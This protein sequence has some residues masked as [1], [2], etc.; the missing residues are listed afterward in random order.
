MSMTQLNKQQVIAINHFG[1]PLMI[2]AGAGSGKTTV[3]TQKMLHLIEKLGFPGDQILAI[4]FTNKASREMS[5]RIK[6]L[7][8][9]AEKIPYI[10]TFHA[11]CGDVLRRNFNKIGGSNNFVIFDSSD[12][13]RLVKQILKEKKID[14]KQVRPESILSRIE[15]L[16]THLIGYRA[17]KNNPQKHQFDP[18]LAAIYEAY[19]LTLWHSKAVDFGD[20][21]FWVNV[22]FKQCPEVLDRYQ[23]QYKYILID[24]YQD[25]NYAQYM[26]VKS[27]ASK[28][29]NLT[30]VGDF[31]QNIYSW[32]GANIKNMINFEADYTEATTI[33]LEQNYRS[34]KRIL[35]AANAVIKHND[36]RKEKS[37]WTENNEGEKL[38]R[39]SAKNEFNEA[40]FITNSI[41][42]HNKKGDALNHMVIL[43][44]M[45][46][47]S[48]VIEDQLTKAS[49][50]YRVVGGTKFFD[51]KEIKDLIAYL[52][53][54][55]NPHDN[56]AFQRIANVPARDIGKLTIDRLVAWSDQKKR[57]IYNLVKSNEEM[58]V[59][60]RAK[61]AVQSF[62]SK[63]DQIHC[64]YDSLK[65][66]KIAQLC[67]AVLEVS[68]YNKMLLNENS[69]KGQERYENLMEFKSLAREEEMD[70]GEFLNK[71]ALNTDLDQHKIA[72]DA[73]TL[74][75]LHNAK[76]LEYKHVYICAL[77]EGVLPHYRSLNEKDELEEERRLCYVGIT[78]GKQ[79]VTLSSCDQRTMFGNMKIQKPSRFFDEIPNEL[80]QQKGMT[81]DRGFVPSIK[82]E[83]HKDYTVKNTG[84]GFQ[85]GDQVQ[86][87]AWGVGTIAT[88]IGNGPEAIL[89][90]MFQG[91]VKK[92]MAKYAP[93]QKI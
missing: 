17:Y 45:N 48:R 33:L 51:R 79:Y 46:A 40:E 35:Q 42:T 85:V 2:V 5:D 76:G 32:R 3:I 84:E 90:V 12:Q 4:T 49:L 77:E 93:I 16:K 13:K 57:S 89:T 59:S 80:L 62:F 70:L 29:Q 56:F 64:I 92:L 53:I 11:F 50:P 47:L 34:T 22:L 8:T 20:M 27:L 37:L 23:E 52:R 21:I 15:R 58:P 31:D 30:V 75:T 54:V 44:R 83:I 72:E 78:R 68:E 6:A 87:A 38:I 86:H 66:D 81:F 61:S 43:F 14:E 71:M 24:E 65:T 28:Y 88:K 39:F 41:K 91:Q 69:L 73:V 26:L 7:C 63:L 18:E 36:N 60:I 67:E 1:T 74:M 19:Q 25:T 55:H 10:S 82:E 9:G